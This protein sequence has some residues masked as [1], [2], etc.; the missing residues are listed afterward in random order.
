MD[1]QALE[2]EI[3]EDLESL[4]QFSADATATALHFEQDVE[5]LQNRFAEGVSDEEL[6][7]LHDHVRRMLLVAPDIFDGLC[8]FFPLA[9]GKQPESA[10]FRRAV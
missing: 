9:H 2:R 4:R 6:T 1:R 3:A 10:A 7:R 5:A 8:F